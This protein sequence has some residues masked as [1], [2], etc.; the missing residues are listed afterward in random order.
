MS[1]SV[2]LK[3]LVVEQDARMAATRSIVGRMVEKWVVLRCMGAG[4]Y[5]WFLQMV[6]AYVLKS[7][8]YDNAKKSSNQCGWFP[9]VLGAMFIL[10]CSSCHAHPATPSRSVQVAQ[11][12]S[13]N[14][15]RSAPLFQLL[16]PVESLE[17]DAK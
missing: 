17:A 13:L 15:S 12:Q 5:K 10:P 9:G 6:I 14:P 2:S 1:F 3:V 7:A 4:F 8:E 11:S 16:R